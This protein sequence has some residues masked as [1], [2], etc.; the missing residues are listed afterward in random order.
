[1][2]KDILTELEFSPDTKG[3]VDS[4]YERTRYECNLVDFA[5]LFRTIL[6][7]LKKGTYTETLS[8]T[9]IDKITYN[10]TFTLASQEFYPILLQ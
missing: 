9:E 8:D 3:I 4:I 10:F 6:T 1:M 5:A 2:K 7:F